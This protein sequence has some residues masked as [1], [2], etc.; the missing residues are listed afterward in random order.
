MS[1]STTTDRSGALVKAGAI[2]FLIGAAAT[3]ATFVPLF[4]DLTPLPTAAYW[5]SML[6]PLGLAAALA[7]MFR[8]ARAKKAPRDS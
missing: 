8:E 6:M 2:V 7:G 3:L 5:I 4:L 1:S